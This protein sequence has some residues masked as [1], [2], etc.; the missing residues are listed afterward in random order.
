MIAE[1]GRLLRL[2]EKMEA[3]ILVRQKREEK[4]ATDWV[5]GWSDGELPLMTRRLAQTRKDAADLLGKLVIPTGSKDPDL[6][7]DEEEVTDP[8]TIKLRRV[9]TRLVEKGARL[10]DDPLV[11]DE[12]VEAEHVRQRGGRKPE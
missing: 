7:P 4:W 1:V 3:A 11:S 5:D 2:A 10:R 8:Q 9:L 12:D 6:E